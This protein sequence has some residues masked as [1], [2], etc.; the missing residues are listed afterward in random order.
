MAIGAADARMTLYQSTGA[1]PGRD[2]EFPEGWHLS[3][4]LRPPKAHL[5][6]HPW[7]KFETTIEVSV[8]RLDTWAFSAGISAVDFIW[9]D[10]QGAELDLINGGKVTLESTAF[11]YTEYALQEL[12]D[13]QVPLDKIQAALPNH[14]L[15]QRFQH[16]ALFELDAQ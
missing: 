7:C 14:R 4:S 8:Q 15:V 16:D 3:G 13:G 2:E 12:Y 5:D 11:F 1:P 9:A 6:V 10:V